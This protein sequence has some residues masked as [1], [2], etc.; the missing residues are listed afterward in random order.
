MEIEPLLSFFF[1]SFFFFL[2]AWEPNIGTPSL[3]LEEGRAKINYLI[4]TKGQKANI[5]I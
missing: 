1:L 3:N 2:I 4:L 5:Y